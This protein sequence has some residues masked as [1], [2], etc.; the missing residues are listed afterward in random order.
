LAQRLV[1]VRYFA[2]FLRDF[3]EARG[4]GGVLEDEQAAPATEALV[5][6]VVL[7]L[8]LKVG[9][10]ARR[11]RL[12]FQLHEEYLALDGDTKKLTFI[13]TLQLY[14]FTIT[15]NPRVNDSKANRTT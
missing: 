11:H 14:H 6:V 8:E 10:S 5:L 1:L 9:G 7:S 2:S 15:K 4:Q 3:V 12:F 13:P